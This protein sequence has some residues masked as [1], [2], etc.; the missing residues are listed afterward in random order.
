M[1]N[2]R[3]AMILE[4]RAFD[5]SDRPDSAIAA[6][7]R[8]VATPEPDL[9]FTAL[10]QAGSYKRL[11]ELYEAKGDTARAI[12]NY[13]RFIDLWRDAE[14]VLQPKLREARARLDRLR[15]PR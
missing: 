12:M 10:Y 4:A 13:E 11:G 2:L 6:F 8:F 3:F 15:P 5:L 1:I 9:E 7:E 14:P